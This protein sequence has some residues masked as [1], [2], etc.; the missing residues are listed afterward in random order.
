MS[1][2]LY[3]YT[4]EELQE[5]LDTSNGYC[6]LLRKVGLNGHGANPETLKKIISEYGLDTTQNSKNRSELYRS[7]AYGIHFKTTIPLADILN[8]EYPNYQP[9]R[10]LKRLVEEGYKA[11]AC[12]ICG[13][14]EYNNHPISLQ[15]HHMDGNREN[16]SLSN[17]QILCPNCHSQ[18]DNFSGRSSK[19][20]DVELKK[21]KEKRI[22]KST[23]NPPLDRD[24]LKSKIRSI[25]F[26]KIA[27]D[28]GVTDNAVRKWCKKY[29]L[30]FKKSEI[31]NITEEDWEKI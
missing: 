9:S 24:A 5:M 12:E 20:K 17:L 1:S 31:K 6:D 10:L 19:K 3:N 7:N 4:P 23:K 25:P 27:N 14:A 16:N 29:N 18:T 15:L 26:T 21:S 13:I 2:I 22:W 8:G 28:L 30:P 11:Y